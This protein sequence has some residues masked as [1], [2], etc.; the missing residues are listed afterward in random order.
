[1]ETSSSENSI[2]V[3][4][5]WKKV[6]LVYSK[7]PKFV[8]PVNAEDVDLLTQGEINQLEA[9]YDL[10]SLRHTGATKYANAMMPF[11]LLML[12]TGHVNPNVLFNVYVEVNIQKMTQEWEKIQATEVAENI[13]SNVQKR[14]KDA[15]QS[16]TK[17][18]LLQNNRE[19]LLEYLTVNHYFSVGSF[20][21]KEEL[22]QKSLE[23]FSHI[24]PIFWTP[25]RFGFCT[26]SSCPPGLENRCSLCP[27]HITCPALLAKLQTIS[28]Y[29]IFVFK[30]I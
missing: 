18:M 20:L 15:I 9:V 5:R 8:L 30:N 11:S 2:R 4:T 1:M 13:F 7:D 22:E 6:V 10:H 12:L 25:K 19:E 27:H 28:I 3:S 21:G 26:S 23:D 24:D 17:E 16:K 14:Y 29:R